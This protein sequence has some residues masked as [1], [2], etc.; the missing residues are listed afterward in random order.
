LSVISGTGAATAGV[1]QGDVIVGINSTTINGAQDVS[2]VI[3]AL[4]PGDVVT[5]H[6]VRGK[7]HIVIKVTLGSQPSS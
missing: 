1:K 6:L 3:S 7:H 5:L 4:R 2:S